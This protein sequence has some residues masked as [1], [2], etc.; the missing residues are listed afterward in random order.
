[1]RLNKKLRYEIYKMHRRIRN[2]DSEVSVKSSYSQCFVGFVYQINPRV[3]LTM[4]GN[5]T[6]VVTLFIQMI[7]LEW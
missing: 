3:K 7:L 6:I 4:A 2:S 1:M 5:L